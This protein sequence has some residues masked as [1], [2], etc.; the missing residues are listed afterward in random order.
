MK[1]Y[2]GDSVKLITNFT[3]ETMEARR[4]KECKTGNHRVTCKTNVFL[5][6]NYQCMFVSK[7]SFF[8]SHLERMYNRSVMKLS[9]STS[10]V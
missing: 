7:L 5:S 10:S 1:S 8:L 2:K 6:K 9:W 4:N 3:S